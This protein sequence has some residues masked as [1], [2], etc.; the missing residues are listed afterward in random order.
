MKKTYIFLLFIVFLN[1]VIAQDKLTLDDCID[2]ALN[3][4]LQIQQNILDVE[5]Q[6]LTKNKAAWNML[7]SLNLSASQDYEFG[8]TIDPTTNNRRNADFLSNSFNLRSRFNVLDLASIKNFSKASTD[9][10]KSLVDYEANKNQILLT[11]TQFYLDVMFKTEYIE[12]LKNQLKESGNQYNRLT[13]ALNFGYIAR[14]E[15]Y[16]AEADFSTDKKLLLLAENNKNKA[17]LNLLNLINYSGDINNVEFADLL[18]EVDS[19]KVGD[20]RYF[21][22]KGIQNNP[23]ILSADYL[24]ESAKKNIGINRAAGLPSISLTYQYGSFYSRNLSTDENEP[25]FEDQID[26]NLSQFVGGTLAIPV[27]NGLQNRFNIKIA[28]VEHEKALINKEIVSNQLWY[29]IR[30]TIQDIENA[31][32]TYQTSLNVFRAAK[33]SFRTSKLKYEQGKVSA[34]EFATS[35]KNLLQS[36]SDVLDSKFKLYY[37][38]TKLKFLTEKEVGE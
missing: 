24:V 34:F 9:Y 35:K 27:F 22:N 10:E 38:K 2:I 17:V 15:L 37:N 18:F 12:L 28:K 20:S 8:F 31:I 25:E 4:N 1:S 16:D 11:I 3:N 26:E 21:Y 23:N 7:P 19:T 14:S 5:L 36:E 30:Q 29:D 32:A 13:E 33:E 6:R